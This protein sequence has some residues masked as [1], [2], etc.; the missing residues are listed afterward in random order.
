MKFRPLAPWVMG[1]ESITPKNFFNNYVPCMEM[2]AHISID[3]GIDL[4]LA[5]TVDTGYLYDSWYKN[6]EYIER[7]CEIADVNEDNGYDLDHEEKMWIIEEL[8]EPPESCYNI[9]FITVYND[10]EERIVYIGKTDSKKSRFTN[11]HLAALK[12]HNPI[13]NNYSKRIYYGTITFLSKENEYIPLE[14]I[15]PYSQANKYLSEFEGLLIAHFKPELNVKIEKVGELETLIVHIQNFSD[16]SCF[17]DDE[18]IY[19]C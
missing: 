4:Y 3:I 15:T 14:F 12:L 16:V 17:L 8:G 1:N 13:Y 18:M 7:A 6:K 9:Y 19:G 11:G 5:N 2:G 10:M